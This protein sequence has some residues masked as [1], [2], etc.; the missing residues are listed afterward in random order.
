VLKHLMRVRDVERAVW[1]RQRV[2]AA[3]S[4][5]KIGQ[6]ARRRIA[7]RLLEGVARKI[8]PDD[9]ARCDAFC[10]TPRDASGPAA[11]VEDPH[12]GSQLRQQKR[13]HLCGGALGM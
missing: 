4:I 5:L 8:D 2:D 11:D 9:L 1:K 6:S 13:R 12:P 3:L 7:L 10:E